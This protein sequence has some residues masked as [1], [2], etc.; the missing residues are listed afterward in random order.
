MKNGKLEQFDIVKKGNKVGVIHW[1]YWSRWEDE[2]EYKV[3]W[4]TR[5]VGDFETTNEWE[6]DLE[7]VP[8]PKGEEPS[9]HNIAYVLLEGIFA[10]RAK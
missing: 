7:H 3:A 9:V 8:H 4:R 6:Y 10:R 2:G 1:V 5:L